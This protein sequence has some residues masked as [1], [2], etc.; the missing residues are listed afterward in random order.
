VLPTASRQRIVHPHTPE[1]G[2]SKLTPVII[3]DR[4]E[5]CAAFWEERL[6]YRRTA[7]VPGTDGLAFVILEKD[8]IELMYQA[9]GAIGDG[10]PPLSRDPSIQL[11]I[12]VDDLDAVE[13]AMRDI[14]AIPRHD[15]F[16]GMTEIAVRD[17]AGTLVVFAHPAAAP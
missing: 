9:H 1:A 6:G 16:Y 15:T 14:I 3:V 7:E 17:P 2:M 10:A 5:P 8:G 12:E 4:V 11:F 13:R